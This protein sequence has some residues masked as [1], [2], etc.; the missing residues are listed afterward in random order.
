MQLGTRWPVGGDIP[1]SLPESVVAAVRTV[2][3][4]I[5]D[6]DTANWRWTLTY[7]EGRPIVDLDDGTQITHDP[8]DGSATTR[9]AD[10]E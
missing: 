9:A 8:H 2:E 4:E 6:I 5:A 1:R 3:A 10:A 7:L